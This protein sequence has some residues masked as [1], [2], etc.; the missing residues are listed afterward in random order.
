MKYPPQ[1]L[2]FNRAYKLLLLLVYLATGTLAQN[3]ARNWCFG[4]GASLNFGTTPPSTLAATNMTVV[5]GCATI[6]SPAGAL[7]FYTDGMTIWNSSYAIMANGTG[8]FG[9]ST[10]TQSSLI[11]K[12]PGSSTSYYVFTVQGLSGTAGL[13][14]SIV[15]MSLAAGQGSVTVKNAPLY[16]S[17]LCEKLTATR[18]CNGVDWWIVVREWAALT[19]GTN[20]RAYQLTP[21]GMN[22]VAVVSNYTTN[23]NSVNTAYGIGAMKISPT[24]KKLAL[25]NYNYNNTNS[26]TTFSTF[27]LFD[28][29]NSTGVVSN[30]LSL[31][32]NLTN[33]YSYGY[34][35]EFS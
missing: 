33:V 28:F 27:D 19:N 24:G 34:G 2:K 4:Y 25:A 26:L 21:A 13:N 3:E 5:E 31:M 29:D 7:L 1:L 30:S 16:S 35:V 18:H 10:P 23:P 22:T 6:S 32:P 14:Y 8:L 20:F 12:R 17:S 11:L 15:D 9:N